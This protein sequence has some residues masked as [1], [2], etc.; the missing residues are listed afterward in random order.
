[1]LGSY[2]LQI[3]KFFLEFNRA[4][5]LLVFICNNTKVKKTIYTNTS[6]PNMKKKKE[7]KQIAT[8]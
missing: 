2:V 5:D 3:V 1:M 4:K 6:R 8:P 7:H